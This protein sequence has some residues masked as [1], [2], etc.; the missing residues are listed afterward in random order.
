MGTQPLVYCAAEQKQFFFGEQPVGCFEDQLPFS[1]GEYRYVPLDGSAHHYFIKALA[2]GPQ[3]CYYLS[4]G[5]P[6]Y[7]IVLNT[8]SE[9]ILLVHAHTYYAH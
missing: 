4:E 9:G 1:S 3:R 5:K 2:S 8:A 7:F 6:H